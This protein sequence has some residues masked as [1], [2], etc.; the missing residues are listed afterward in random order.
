MA[1]VKRLKPAVLYWASQNPLQHINMINQHL[2]FFF[3]T[4]GNGIRQDANS[5]VTVQATKQAHSLH[6]HVCTAYRVS[7]RG[8]APLAQARS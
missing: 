2:H 1:L 3:F 7:W 8:S 4:V 5:S 6:R